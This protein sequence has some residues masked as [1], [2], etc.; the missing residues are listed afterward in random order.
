MLK[1]DYI[2][3]NRKVKGEKMN[4][5]KLSGRPTRQPEIRNYPKK[6]KNGNDVYGIIASFVLAVDIIAGR[7]QE[8]VMFIRCSGFGKTAEIIEKRV[9]QGDKI[10]VEGHIVPNNYTKDN[11]EIYSFQVIAENIEFCSSNRN[12]GADS[13]NN[14]EPEESAVNP[15]DEFMNT[16]DDEAGELPTPF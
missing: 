10:I 11:V 6:D 4:S 8:E 5:V 12:R 13:D 16:L 9:E 2:L 7:K 3:N 1:K 14:A 15:E